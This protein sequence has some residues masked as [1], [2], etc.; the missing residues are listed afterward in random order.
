MLATTQETW[1]Q[2]HSDMGSNPLG[3]TG[4]DCDGLVGCT[5]QGCS[6]NQVGRELL[7]GP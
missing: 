3:D 6:E 1:V 4:P 2:I 7:Y 5:L